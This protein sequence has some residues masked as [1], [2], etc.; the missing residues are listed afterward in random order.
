MEQTS[1]ESNN[2]DFLRGILITPFFTSPWKDAFENIEWEK[3][4][5]LITNERGEVIF[6][7]RGVEVPKAWSQMASNVVV[8]KYFRG[9]NGTSERENS[10]RS[11]ISRIV[12]TIS[13][14]GKADGYFAE[15]GDSQLFKDELAYILVHQ[16]AS[17]NSP[18]WFNV[19]INERPQCSA[20][21]IVAV[22]DSLESI[23]ELQ[24]IEG[25]LFKH[26]SGT[27]S[28][29]ST[30]RSSRE[31]LTGGGIPSGPVSFMR[32]FDAWAGI[33]KSGGKTRR[34]AKMQILNATH[35]DI[36]EFISAKTDE[37]KKAWALIEQG[38][39]GGFAVP[40]GAYE[41]VAFQ[42]AN[43]SVRVEDDFMQAADNDRTYN[44]FKVSNGE[45]CEKLNAKE[46]L[47][48]IAKGTHLCGDPGM[49]FHSTINDWHTCPNS[50]PI[51]ASNPCSEYMHVDNSAC[52]LSSIN[53]LRFLKEDGSF[54]SAAFEHTVKIMMIAQ[55][56]L[57]DRSSYP[58]KKI[59]TNARSFRQ[60]G[61][62]YANLGALLMNLGLPYDSDEGRS[63]A[64]AITALM[65]GQA[66]L[67]SSELAEI[68]GAFGAYKK[69][70]E[71]ML[72][73]LEKHR[74]ALQDIPP[75]ELVEDILADAYAVWESA[76][77]NGREFGFRNA[78][79]TVLAPTG[80]ISFMMDCDTTGIE[81][82]IA[83]VKYKKLVG[84]GMLKIV[85]Q[86][87]SSALNKLGYSEKEV[88]EIT[89]YISEN[90][91]IE[92]APKLKAEHL[93]VFDCA[94]KAAKGKRVISPDGHL[95]MM[96]AVQPFISG[97]ISKTVN[98][99]ENTSIEEIADIYMRAWKM[100]LKAV[101]LYRDGSK[102]TQPLTTTL[103]GKQKVKDSTQ[104]ARRR[105]SDE[106]SAITHK[107]QV[108]GLEGYLTVGLFEDGRPGEIF[109]VVAKEG[110]TLS[111]V[112]DAFATSISIALQ[113]GVPLNALVRKFSYLRFDPSGFTGNKSIPMA[114]SLIDYIFR[115]LGHKFLTPSEIM[116]LGLSP[117][118]NGSVQSPKP[119]VVEI[120]PID[121]GTSGGYHAGKEGAAL[122]QNSE[123]APPCTTCGS[124]LMVRQA[125]CYVCLNC[126]AQG[127]C[128]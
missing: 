49:Q 91:C 120:E 14:W 17:F 10:V 35:P 92:G 33:I 105:L 102:R 43:L 126:G 6:E 27:G 22:E 52:N 106:R 87:V 83:L 13:N 25:K 116:E 63:L 125:G 64:A 42:N 94:F 59:E 65:T 21:F 11:L 73:V 38:Y 110:S 96:A 75:N 39:D 62:G 127:G 89:D 119:A 23:L 54:D 3:R 124:S 16:Y 101:A 61:L 122:F 78:Q 113:Y 55:D 74:H 4:D 114:T 44:T 66:Y 77:E 71:P 7:Q 88:S 123:D 15:T 58:T 76:L 56:I 103:N 28:N 53:L 85:N 70:S 36:R 111:G 68:K 72:K 100:K 32:G 47:K 118:R 82:D 98:L 80:T 46:V 40:G 69:N 109:L 86:S 93:P 24:S 20:C 5:C 90:D 34:A 79:A 41:S 30:L 81:P 9:E 48:L 8:S 51:R 115:W 31:R 1:N 12:D 128:G 45:P 26:G 97:A 37:E 99:P 107:F 108:G 2:H 67:T 95:K 50:G 57:I 117:L 84:G 112:M 121:G 29:L 104:P 18:V 19:G 60:L